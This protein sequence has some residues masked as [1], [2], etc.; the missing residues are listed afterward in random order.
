MPQVRVRSLD[1]NLG[2]GRTRRGQD[3][4]NTATESWRKQ[5]PGYRQRTSR[6][7][8]TEES[9]ILK[10]LLEKPLFSISGCLELVVGLG[11]GTNSSRSV[12]WFV[13]F[14]EKTGE[15]RREH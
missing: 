3:E 5:R 1:A 14:L 2:G 15:A 10:F 8:G 12:V 9:V 6:T 7:W 13:L 11:A 4:I